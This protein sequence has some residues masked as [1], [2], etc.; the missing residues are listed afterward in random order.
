M[1]DYDP[2]AE[3]YDVANRDG[4]FNTYYER[5]EMLRM[6]GDVA[7]LQV[8]DAGC[9]SGPLSLALRE[10]GAE[11]VGFDASARMLDLARGRLG[12]EA[13]L[14]VHDLAEPLPYTD[15]A[16][17]LVTASLV[18]HYLEDWSGPLAELRRVLRPGGR[19]LVSI[20]HPGIYKLVYPK[21]DYFAVHEYSEDH[22]FD[23][24]TVWLTYWHRP[25]HA[26]LN[27]FLDAGFAIRRVT[28]PPPAPDT[29]KE[30]LPPDFEGRSF[31]CFLF[32]ELQAD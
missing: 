8:L 31:L 9:G 5:P 12:A 28:E 2:F 21:A 26:V 6:A 10:R 24:Q 30:L 7:G 14:R 22:D 16:F 13:D 23:G 32:V 3:A 19:L 1:T 11:V 18:L 17:D 4:L 20:N 29:P 15:A 25:L 27:A